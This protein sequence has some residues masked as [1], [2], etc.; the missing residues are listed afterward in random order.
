MDGEKPL[1]IAINALAVDGGGG[2]TYLENLLRELSALDENNK[3]AILLRN[4]HTVKI[5]PLTSRFEIL[6]FPIPRPFLLGR[7]FIEQF[8]LPFWLKKEKID[9][10]Y[11]PA[12]ATT[13]LSPCP[14][15]LAMRNP[16]LYL[17]KGI[18]WSLRYKMKFL[19]LG[20]LA[21]LSGKKAKQIIFVSKAS[22]KLVC[23]KITIP[24]EKIT[25]IHHG[26]SPFF[27]EKSAPTPEIARIF[28]NKQPYILSISSIYRYKNY[29]RLIEAF[30]KIRE[31]LPG[32]YH[33]FIIGSSFDNAYFTQMLHRIATLG[34]NDQ[35]HH[36][37]GFRLEALASIYQEARLFAFPSFLETFGHPLVEAMASGIPIAAADIEPTREITGGAARYFDPQ[38]V[39]SMA[40]A[41]LETLTDEALRADLVKRGKLQVA[42]F[43]WTQCAKQTLSVFQKAI[44]PSIASAPLRNSSFGEREEKR[45]RT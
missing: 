31:K 3:Y 10:L 4:N 21:K 32:K 45:A 6:T 20:W 14:V 8:F 17:E 38:D 42:R 19:V 26:V 18:G 36:L 37:G 9:L 30:Y 43:S 35:V 22:E 25:V 33:L 15:V 12:D 23:R 16:N 11:S 41:L 44:D 1:K 39:D 40:A 27:F 24:R 7:F 29:I 5:P 2:Q 28:Q 34:L 13:L